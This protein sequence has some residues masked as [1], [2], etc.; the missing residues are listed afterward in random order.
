[1]LVI[2]NWKSLQCSRA[3]LLEKVLKNSIWD[4][5]LLTISAPLVK[6]LTV[7]GTRAIQMLHWSAWFLQPKVQG[8]V[9]G[10]CYF[11]S[12]KKIFVSWEIKMT[13]FEA[14]FNKYRFQNLIGI[15]QLC[16]LK[17]SGSVATVCL[18]SNAGK[19]IKQFLVKSGLNLALWYLEY[20]PGDFLYVVRQYSRTRVFLS[21]V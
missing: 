10:M 12:V 13:W 9:K 2:N 1:M 5:S 21:F 3:R 4:T 19:L 11:I 17:Y 6:C 14:P 7:S 20:F 18:Y 16:I 8:N 15:I